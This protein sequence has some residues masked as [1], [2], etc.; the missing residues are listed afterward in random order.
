MAT[1][2]TGQNITTGELPSPKKSDLGME[3]GHT[4]N[5]P[6]ANSFYSPTAKKGTYEV[7]P[8]NAEDAPS[9]QQLQAMR[10]T[11]GQS[12]A[13]YRLITLPVRSSLKS[14][15][16]VSADDGGEEE[17]EFIKQ[18]FTL[19]PTNGGMQVTFSQVISQM[20]MAIF[21]GFAPFEEVY[22][23]PK[24]GPLKGKITL[25]KAAYRPAETIT[26][27]IDDQ[28]EFAGLRQ[29]VA[30]KGEMKDISIPGERCFWV[31]ANDEER[32]FYGVSYF[33]SAFYHYDK[34][35][36]LYYLAHLAAQHRAVGSRI[37]KVPGGA[38]TPDLLRFQAALSDFGFAQ[39]LL[40]PPGFEVKNE[41]PSSNYDFLAM[42]NH[43]NSQM[44]KSVLA[45]FFDNT[46]GGDKTIVDFGQ[47]SDA[48]F[49]MMLQTVMSE[50]ADVI[51]NRIIPKF[52]DWNFGTGKY[53][54][55]SWGT[56]TD[57]QR[58]AISLLFD[59][60]ATSGSG[61][62]VSP[63]FMNE[64]EKRMAQELGLNIDYDVID[65]RREQQMQAQ[66]QADGE[67]SQFLQSAGLDGA[68]SSE[69]Q[70]GV[71][72]PQQAS[73]HS[74]QDIPLSVQETFSDPDVLE[75]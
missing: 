47:Q 3:F 37:G 41:Y 49:I 13:L 8:E 58:R 44:S 5:L 39:S 6:F 18:M 1:N 56:F 10:R 33:Q 17:A 20:L 54:T 15:K 26:F 19:P 25:Q 16:F 61:V 28:S 72:T 62:N 9:I 34:K 57:E 48:M 12:R 60:L 66:Q 22:T 53:P 14:A 67:F 40:L 70:P 42:I 63:E 2:G 45:P 64:L 51:N 27:L 73:A 46:E 71:N 29:R 31:S 30:F 38:S 32:P 21:D 50:I 59:R 43:H 36:K 52:I 75:I 35:V 74:S 11:D 24:V 55:F 69:V 7:L 68:P 4:I 65:A 23:V